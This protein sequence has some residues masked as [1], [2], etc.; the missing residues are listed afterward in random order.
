[1]NMTLH[2]KHLIQISLEVCFC[3]YVLGRTC[4]TWSRVCPMKQSAPGKGKQ[5]KYNKIRNSDDEKHGYAGADA[6]RGRERSRGR[7][8]ERERGQEAE[9]VKRG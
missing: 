5:R 8:E 9:R 7:E 1:M 6:D 3:F 2:Y 4:P